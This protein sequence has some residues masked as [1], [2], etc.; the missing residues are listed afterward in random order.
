MDKLMHQIRSTNTIQTAA[1]GT[2]QACESGWR[3][4]PASAA[5]CYVA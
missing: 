1:E 5:H 3:N 4:G 2:L